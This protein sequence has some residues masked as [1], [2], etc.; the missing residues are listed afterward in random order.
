V[1]VGLMR[2]ADSSAI[3]VDPGQFAWAKDVVG[4]VQRVRVSVAFSC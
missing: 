2:R 3:G 4:A 1:G